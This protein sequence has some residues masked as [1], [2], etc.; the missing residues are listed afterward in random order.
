MGEAS[1]GMAAATSPSSP[2]AIVVVGGTRGET[3][4]TSRLR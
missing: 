1:A 2:A 4:L 3:L